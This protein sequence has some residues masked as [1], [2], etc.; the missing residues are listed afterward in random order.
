VR[1]LLRSARAAA[2]GTTL[3]IGSVA[4]A[5]EAN[6]PAEASED[7]GPTP[8]DRALA[9]ALFRE[10]K[11]LGEDGRIPEACLKFKESQRLD[12]TIGTL[13]HLAACYS[14]EGKTASAWAAY[15]AAA[16]M[17]HRAKQKEREELARERAE[18]LEARLSRVTITAAAAVEGLI[19]ELDGRALGEST[20]S[21]PLPIDPGAHLL[22]ASAPGKRE[23]SQQFEI[24]AE[25]AS[26]TIEVPALED[27][28][29][30]AAPVAQPR[31]VA[32]PPDQPPPEQRTGKRIAGFVVGGVGLAGIGVGSYFGLRAKSQA[33]DANRFCRGSICNQEGLDG[34]D[35]AKGSALIAN[36]LFG[37]GIV[38][39]VAGTYLIVT[40]G[41]VEP[42]S[43]Q[44][45][46]LWVGAGPGSVAAGGA[47]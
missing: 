6:P 40:S 42:S 14:E 22:K 13:L 37:V 9:E 11:K 29:V 5:Q 15:N 30:E 7:Q 4:S 31:A 24:A 17:A 26:Q 46:A 45:A 19:V 34:H 41:P 18:E 10:G 25:P 39:V 33:D 47:F 28:P 3:L 16:D 20:L 12:P 2:L 32:P 35:D 43:T 27:A 21:T 1:G 23:W 38:G 44:S 36:V 8:Q